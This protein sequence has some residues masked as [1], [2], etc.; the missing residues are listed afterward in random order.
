M[1]EDR[2][3]RDKTEESDSERNGRNAL[4]RS[5][6]R[7]LEITGLGII[8]SLIVS[9]W[10]LVGDGTI[11]LSQYLIFVSLMLI[12]AGGMVW[13]LWKLTPQGQ[14]AADRLQPGAYRVSFRG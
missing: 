13:R 1:S 12:S 6:G 10:S 4:L 11:E 5:R 8:I 2:D 9:F 3:K 14:V 7:S